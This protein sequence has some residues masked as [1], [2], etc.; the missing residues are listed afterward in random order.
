MEAGFWQRLFR[1][2]RRLL[3]SQELEEFA[4]ADWPER[5]MEIPVTDRLHVKQGRSI[6]RWVLQS[7]NRSLVVYLKRHY[8]LPRRYGLLALL[9]PDAGWSPAL[10]EWKHLCWARAQGLPVPEV[11]AGGEYIGPWGRLQSFL[12]VKELTDMLPLHEAIPAAASKLPPA[13]FAQWKRGLAIE[14]ARLAAELH[15]RHHFHKDLYLCHFYVAAED[16]TRQ[17]AWPGR[18]RLIDLHRLGHHRWTWPWRLAKD[19]GQLWYSSE[20]TGV[21]VRDRV[22][23]WRAYRKALSRKQNLRWLRALISLKVGSYRRHSRRGGRRSIPQS[24]TTLS[25]PNAA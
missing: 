24:A 8:R 20:V 17:V 21:T 3:R 14:I 1:G 18:V 15:R 2:E 16:T 12:A 4:G 11:V 7:G 19:L 13:D 10:S 6:G 23:F 25:R 22:C 5:I 9:W